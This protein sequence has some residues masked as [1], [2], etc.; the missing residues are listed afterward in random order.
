MTMPNWGEIRSAW[1]EWLPFAEAGERIDPY[2][3]DWEFTP[4]E[5]EGW[6]SIRRMGLPLYPQVPVAGYFLDFGD[7]H[8]LIGVELDGAKYHDA[9]RDLIRDTKLK[10]LG[11]RIFR[12]AGREANR[13]IMNPFER[14]ECVGCTYERDDPQFTRALGEWAN[15][16]EEGVL[17]ALKTVF[18]NKVAR[19]GQERALALSA[20]EAHS[21]QGL[22]FCDDDTEL[23]IDV[24]DQG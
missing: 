12:I 21:L 20:L 6:N 8:Q 1:A 4:I 17:W 15:N 3:Y 7:P 11:W 14:M 5:Q 10:A 22:A 18:Y 9:A 2:F 19:N 23:E 16:T 24:R 13:R